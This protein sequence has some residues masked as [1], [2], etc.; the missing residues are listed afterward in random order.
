MTGAKY[1]LC[2]ILFI[3]PS[4]DYVT[5][6]LEY[7]GAEARTKI[8]TPIRRDTLPAGVLIRS[9]LCSLI[10]PFEASPWNASDRFSI[11]L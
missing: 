6:Y 3:T 7:Q 9:D 5:A 11:T 4:I 1:I 8:T 2:Y 10:D